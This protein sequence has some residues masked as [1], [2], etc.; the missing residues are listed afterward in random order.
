V[1][2]TSWAFIFRHQAHPAISNFFSSDR[3]ATYHAEHDVADGEKG[4]PRGIN[5]NIQLGL[6]SKLLFLTILISAS[7]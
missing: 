5:W 4:G 3:P 2:G 7:I 1:D 6:D